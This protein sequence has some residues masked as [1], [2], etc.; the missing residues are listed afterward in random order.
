MIV[1]GHWNNPHTDSLTPEVKAILGGKARW[2]T[3]VFFHLKHNIPQGFRY[4][5]KQ[6]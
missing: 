1:F 2:K 4:L 6:M 3:S 5:S